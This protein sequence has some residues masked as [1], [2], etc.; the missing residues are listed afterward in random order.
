MIQATLERQRDTIRWWNTYRVRFHVCVSDQVV[1]EAA[2]GKPEFAARRLTEAAQLH[3]LV[4]EPEDQLLAVEL[5]DHKL[6]PAI[7]KVDALHLAIAVRTKMDIVL[8]W[9]LKHL[10]NPQVLPLVYNYLQGC[11]RHV[12][13]VTTPS[14][15]MESL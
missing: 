13:A 14:D 1:I 7:A 9:N 4:A 3:L 6:I 10:A 11:G 15:L 2:G 5:V 8:T 12:P